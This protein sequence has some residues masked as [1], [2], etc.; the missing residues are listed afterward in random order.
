MYLWKAE[1]S[2]DKP[3]LK[4]TYTTPDYLDKET[5]KDLKPYLKSQPV[6]LEWK[7]GKFVATGRLES[8][9]KVILFNFFVIAECLC[10]K[11]FILCLRIKYMKNR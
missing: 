1:L 8:F 6:C 11:T 5:A 10:C 9:V 7:E 3:V 2:S 4:F